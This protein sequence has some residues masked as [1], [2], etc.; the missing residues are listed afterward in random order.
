MLG[1]RAHKPPY[2]GTCNHCGH[3]CEDS[4]CPLGQ[5]VLR[6][7]AGPCPALLLSQQGV[8]ACGLV[9]EPHKWA[10]LRALIHGQKALSDAALQLIGASTGCDAR[11]E[12]EPPNPEYRRRMQAHYNDP[13]VQ[14]QV[15]QAAMVWGLA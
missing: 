12:E 10:P 13:V 5:A 2:G 6:Q 15:K 3:C 8:S 7:R 1:H 11:H 14:E 4:V 9:V